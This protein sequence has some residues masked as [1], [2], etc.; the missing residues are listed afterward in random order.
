MEIAKRVTAEYVARLNSM[1][2]ESDAL[3]M[4]RPS[5]RNL[6]GRYYM[7]PRLNPKPTVRDRREDKAADWWS[8]RVKHVERVRSGKAPVVVGRRKFKTTREL[9]DNAQPTERPL[10]RGMRVAEVNYKRGHKLLIPESSWSE[11]K[12]QAAL[13]LQRGD[14]EKEV[15]LHLNGR[16]K[17]THIAPLTRYRNA[18]W[19]TPRAQYE[20][21]STRTTKDGVKHVYLSQISK[22]N[23]M[24]VSKATNVTGLSQSERKDLVTRRKRARRLSQAGGALGLTALAARAPQLLKLATKQTPSLRVTKPVRRIL[25][26]EPSATSASNALTTVGAGVGAMGAFNYSHISGQ[27]AKSEEKAL[28]VK[29]A[30]GMDLSKSVPTFVLNGPVRSKY[31]M[32]RRS[33]HLMGQEHAKQ[34]AALKAEAQAA[35]AT[36]SQRNPPLGPV[37]RAPKRIKAEQVF[38]LKRTGRTSREVARSELSK[39]RIV[40]SYTQ[41]PN[42]MSRDTSIAN[43]RYLP[44]ITDQD[45]H[46]LTH[47]G[48]KAPR[49]EV[50]RRIE[51][52]ARANPA[53]RFVSR[54]RLID[55]P[56]TGAAKLLEPKGVKVH[57]TAIRQLAVHEV[58]AV[59]AAAGAAAA[60]SGVLALRKIG[61]RKSRKVDKRDDRF[62]R[63][64]RERISPK[65]EAGYE[66]LRAG[67]NRYRRNAATSGALSGVNAG[68]A[69]HSAIKRQP[70]WAGAAGTL[71]VVSGMNAYDSA[72][73]AKR[74]NS[75][76]DKIKARA[77]QRKADGIYGKGRMGETM[78]VAKAFGL[79]LRPRLSY[80]TRVGGIVRRGSKTFT[81]RGSIVGTGRLRMP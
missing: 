11:S 31:A 59:R 16:K 49:F 13:Y 27:E 79:P 21:T 56:A 33:A 51:R 54:D 40:T 75:K 74:W 28:K 35:N 55:I 10:Y 6:R 14:K 61:N 77:Y 44:P 41:H 5:M 7:N 1:P 18:E 64:N 68:L 70:V 26:A 73:D 25:A 62:L 63:E 36:F 60:G 20:V 39:S 42:S 8:E 52:A 81:R 17:A 38:A 48:S 46:D 43:G 78:D 12:R 65:A 4:N 32:A 9:I 15:L 30:E 23:G 45:I 2:K 3:D 71:S 47:G 34:L 69:V 57:T 53:R 76:M 37:T 22:T 72:Q 66:Y 58:P 50:T 67:R 80:G 24:D 19:V 29:K